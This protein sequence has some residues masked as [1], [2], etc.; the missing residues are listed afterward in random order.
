MIAPPCRIVY[1]DRSRSLQQ[2][3]FLSFDAVNPEITSSR[4][5]PFSVEAVYRA[6]ADPR[7]LALWW[8]PEGFT[9]R[10]ETF[11][12]RPGGMWS[13]V[14][15]GPDGAAY[16]MAKQFAEVVPGER[17]VLLHLE[18]PQHRFRMSM[19]FAA[20]PR[21]TRLTWHMRFERAEEADRVREVILQ[22]NE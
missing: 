4:L 6:F 10:I 1:R 21:G 15:H 11:E 17:V 20:E 3:P 9:N 13:F 22:A 18:P 2:A 19:E 8:G 14:M 16:A 5:L 12:L 7:A